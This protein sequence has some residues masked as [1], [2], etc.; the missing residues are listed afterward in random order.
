MKIR[1]LF[2]CLGN[3]CRSP[4]AE[5]V[6]LHLVARSRRSPIGSTSTRPAPARGTRANAPTRACGKRPNARGIDAAEPSRVRSQ[7]QDFDRFDHI[8]AM[9]ASNL[10]DL[11][12][13][14]PAAHRDKI[15]LFRDLDPD[16]P[17]EDVPDP[18]LR[19]RRRL[20]RSA[21]YRHP[22]QPGA[23]GRIP[24]P[25]AMTALTSAVER[26]LGRVVGQ[27]VRILRRGT[28]AG[29]SINHTERLDTTAGP[30]VLKSHRAPPPGFFRAEAS[31]LAALGGSG[32][33]LTVPRVVAYED[34]AP[35][36]LLLEFLQEGRRQLDFDE[37]LGRGLAALHRTASTAFGFAEDNYC[38]ATPQIN[39]WGERWVDFYG[40]RRLGYQLRLASRSGL[41]TTTEAARVERLIAHL[42]RLGQRT[43]RRPGA[44]PRRSLVRKPTRGRVGASR[45]D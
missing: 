41:L 10:R 13:L 2:V 28:L 14:A 7:V 15:R 33:T 18:V 6:F 43:G 31:G 35:P 4:A 34:A 21:R 38:G 32:T 22:H 1:I 9:D 23:S 42:G 44:H 45:V 11:R 36:F 17:G 16:G 30:F 26:T 8:F 3:I 24:E 29:G 19:W 37:R 25:A 39:A 27:E 5:G 12:D 40:E 20:R